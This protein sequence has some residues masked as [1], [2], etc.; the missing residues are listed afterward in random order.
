MIRCEDETKYILFPTKYVGPGLF[1]ATYFA[2][3]VFLRNTLAVIVTCIGTGLLVTFIQKQKKIRRK[4]LSE[5]EANTQQQQ[6]QGEQLDSLTTC[7]VTLAAT[8]CLFIIPLSCLSLLIYV[9]YSSCGLFTAIRWGVCFGLLNS[10]AN[11]VVYYWKLPSFRK[12]VQNI[13][14]GVSK[15]FNGHKS[16]SEVNTV[17]QEIS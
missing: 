10:S 1:R 8:F 13:L 17:S 4:E 2:A 14:R 6:Q 11:F 12:A 3:S 16:V 9:N 7:L 15:T 5:G